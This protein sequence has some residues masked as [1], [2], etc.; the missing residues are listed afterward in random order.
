MK[1]IYK[2]HAIAQK[3]Q[4]WKDWFD[5]ANKA[6][7]ADRPDLVVANRPADNAGWRRIDTCIAKIRKG[8][9]EPKCHA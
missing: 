3:Q 9:E 1:G 7:M 4:A 2:L 8:L 5:I 6:L